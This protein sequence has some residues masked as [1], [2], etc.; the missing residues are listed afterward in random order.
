MTKIHQCR[1]NTG[2]VVQQ[3]LFNQHW[4]LP[5]DIEQ[6][7]PRDVYKYILNMIIELATSKQKP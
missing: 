5:P 1:H 2:S 4:P 7:I 6:T 3:L